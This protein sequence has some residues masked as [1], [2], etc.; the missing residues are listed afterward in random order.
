MAAEIL[1]WSYVR[2]ATARLLWCWGNGK[3]LRLSVI[4]AEAEC[5]P[6]QAIDQCRRTGAGSRRRNLRRLVLHRVVF[7]WSVCVGRN[8]RVTSRVRARPR[9]A[10]R[11]GKAAASER[12]RQH[13]YP[14]RSSGRRWQECSAASAYA[15]RINPDYT[16]VTTMKFPKRSVRLSYYTHTTCSVPA[17]GLHSGDFLPARKLRRETATRKRHGRGGSCIRRH[18]HRR[19]RLNC[20]SAGRS[21]LRGATR[22]RRCLRRRCRVARSGRGRSMARA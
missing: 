8:R 7:R 4:P 9:Q 10:D 20:R 18:H 1:H 19:R 21:N 17:S 3:R 14:A 6:L 5:P 12:A 16:P 13:S 2:F 15:P 11:R 22:M